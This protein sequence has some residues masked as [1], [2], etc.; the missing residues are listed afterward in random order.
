MSAITELFTTFGVSWPKFLAQ[1]ITFLIVYLILKKFAFGPVTDMLEIRRNRIAEAE[2]NLSETKAQLEGAEET[3]REI[4][5]KANNDA[6]RMVEEAKE[7][8][9]AIGAKKEE[10][11]RVEAEGIVTKAKQAADRERDEVMTGLKQEFGRLVAG[12][13]SAVTGK[14]L[15]DQD[16][17][18]INE[19]ASTHLN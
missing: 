5:A 6:E 15:N 10:A 4:I 17:E 7:N 1:V 19:E 16:H 13:T 8:A 18:K 12:A 2:A 3:A 9:E 14:V 11:A